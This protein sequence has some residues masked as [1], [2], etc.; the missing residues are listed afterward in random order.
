MTRWLL[1]AHRGT[2]P[3]GN[4]GAR[5]WHPRSSSQS[6]GHRSGSGTPH[7]GCDPVGAEHPIQAAHLEFRRCQ[8]ANRGGPRHTMQ[9]RETWVT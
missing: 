3:G 5:R 4:A 6:A 1:L 9:G 2:I 8:P 7:S